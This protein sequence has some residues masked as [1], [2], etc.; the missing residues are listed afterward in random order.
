MT[1]LS[2]ELTK[3]PDH[4]ITA[5]YDPAYVSYALCLRI[6]ICICRTHSNMSCSCESTMENFQFTSNSSKQPKLSTIIDQEMEPNL[7]DVKSASRNNKPSL[8]K[9]ISS[10]NGYVSKRDISELRKLDLSIDA[11]PFPH[12]R[13]IF[14]SIAQLNAC[15]E[16]IPPYI[17]SESIFCFKAHRSWF[18]PKTIIEKR[19]SIQSIRGRLT[20]NARF[21]EILRDKASKN[22]ILWLQAGKS[23]MDISNE[24]EQIE[25]AYYRK[26][27]GDGTNT[28]RYKSLK[29]D[30]NWWLNEFEHNLNGIRPMICCSG[31]PI[32]YC[33]VVFHE[34]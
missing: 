7:I 22:L 18:F 3:T 16:D 32:F 4:T 6:F 9:R 28:R 2:V 21:W 5:T 29:L 11:I 27:G 31:S 8:I 33:Y 23:W 1:H 25:D 19:D 12:K 30:S 10:K 13:C 20:Y 24:L 26:D 17:L 15:I 34:L 14:I